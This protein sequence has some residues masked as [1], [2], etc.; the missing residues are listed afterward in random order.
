VD[1]GTIGGLTPLHGLQLAR[2][3]AAHIC[4]VEIVAF[5]QEGIIRDP[6]ADRLMEEAMELGADVVGGLPW[7]EYSDDDARQHIDFCFELARR[8]N[9]DIHMLV[10]DTDNPNS[11]SLEYLAIA[12]MRN[13]YEGRVSASHCG[14]LA[15]Y[16]DTHASKVIDMVREAGITIVTNPHISLML[17]GRYDHEPKRRGITRIRELL[18][19]GVNLASGQDDVADPYYP[20]GKPDQLEVASMVCHAAHFNQSHEI[21]NSISMISENAARCM[22]VRD[23]GIKPGDRADLVVLPVED[24]VTAVRLQPPRTVVL[25]KGEPVVTSQLTTHWNEIER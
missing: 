15:A 7:Y 23:Y 24:L 6:G 12:T 19:A 14:A 11:R 21:E 4:D 5:P 17:A 10:D 2:D 20:F 13:G 25:F 22:N 1:I 16:D 8:F 18:E 9:K 3:Q